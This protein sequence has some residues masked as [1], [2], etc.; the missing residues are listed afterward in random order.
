MKIHNIR[1]EKQYDQAKMGDI[2][3]LSCILSTD[4]EAIDDTMKGNYIDL[5]VSDTEKHNN[6][7]LRQQIANQF[8][9]LAD[10]IESIE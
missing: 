2:Y 8:R 5:F 7:D 9:Q 4:S 10:Y 1:Y 3:R 6:V